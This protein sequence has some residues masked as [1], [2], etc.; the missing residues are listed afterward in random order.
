LTY[1]GYF[2]IANGGIAPRAEDVRG[3]AFSSQATHAY[4]MKVQFT[5]GDVDDAAGLASLAGAFLD[6]TFPDLMRRTPDWVDVT[7]GL[8]P[9]T[10]P[11]T[12][13]GSPVA[14]SR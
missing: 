5:S 4:Y 2:F 12:A 7:E 9:A 11:P 13:P 10:K 8:H 14:S 1:A 3:L 6:E